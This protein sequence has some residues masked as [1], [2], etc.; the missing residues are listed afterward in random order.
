VN[1]FNEV[2]KLVAKVPIGKVT[3]YGAIAKKLG[4]SNP[5]V[6]GYA[7]HV[8]KDPDNIPCHRV[9]NKEGLPAKGYAFGGLGIQ[10]QLLENEGVKFVGPRVDL[11]SQL[12]TFK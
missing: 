2:Y 7:L 10:K 5:R 12:F 9:V 1:T 4:I 8:N 3:T 11:S 6:V